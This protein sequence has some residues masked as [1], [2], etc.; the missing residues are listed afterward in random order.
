MVELSDDTLAIVAVKLALKSKYLFDNKNLCKAFWLFFDLL[1]KDR[2]ARRKPSQSEV[3]G[4][5]EERERLE[6]LEKIKP[7]VDEVLAGLKGKVSYHAY[8]AVS[9]AYFWGWLAKHPREVADQ[10]LLELPRLGQKSLDAI[11]I[12]YPYTGPS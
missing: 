5:K 10:S 2:D 1:V 6:K 4:V 8:N 9:R 12:V 3:D 7:L 11:R